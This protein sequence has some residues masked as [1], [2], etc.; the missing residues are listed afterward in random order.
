[1]DLETQFKQNLHFAGI[2][3][4]L[5]SFSII[6][7]YEWLDQIPKH[8]KIW[9]SLWEHWHTNYDLPP[10]YD[11]YILSWHNEAVNLERLRQQAA[12]V[13]A[14]IYVLSDGNRYDCHI[15]G[16]EFVRYIYWHH[17]CNKIDS[18]YPRPFKFQHQPRHKYSAICNRVSQ[19][20]IW[21]ITKLL[22]TAREDSIIKLG[23][24][25]ENKNV[26]NWE[27]ANN[28]TLD[29]LTSTFRQHYLDRC[30]EIDDFDNVS[31][32]DQRYT[33]NPWQNYLQDSVINF[34]N[35]SF[36]YSFMLDTNNVG[37]IH[38]G[39]FLSEKTWKCLVGGRPIISVGQFDT[40]RCLTE[41]GLDFSY[42]F[43]LG[44]DR[45]PGNI[46]RFSKLIDLI[47]HLNILSIKDLQAACAA[48]AQHNREY[49]VTGAFWTRCQ[50]VNNAGINYLLDKL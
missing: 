25:I 28:D 31:D 43:D 37:Y 19:S 39:P 26:H 24:W 13:T 38:L 12:K 40:Y 1:M 2:V 27:P 48:S 29:S 18:W 17:V 49:I 10:G 16:I 33:S 5:H 6:P 7:A 32:N 42:G 50:Q 46:T 21:I 35:E 22:Q 20:K 47:D 3:G 30:F 9:I 44:F 23:T 15:N 14:P 41:L 8:K 11:A 36:H 45:D 34:T 4:P